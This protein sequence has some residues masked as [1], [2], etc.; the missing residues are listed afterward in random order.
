MVHN[1]DEIKK[2]SKYWWIKK[3]RHYL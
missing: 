2:E 1:V 3:L